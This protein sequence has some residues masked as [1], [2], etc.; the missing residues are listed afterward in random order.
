MIHK[1]KTNPINKKT[2]WPQPKS[3]NRIREK[4]ANPPVPFYY[5]IAPLLQFAA[6]TPPSVQLSFPSAAHSLRT[7]K[8]LFYYSIV[9]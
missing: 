5:P 1:P 2:G 7:S 9:L 4:K 8:F 6:A 3:H